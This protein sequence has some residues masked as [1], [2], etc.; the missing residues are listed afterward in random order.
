LPEDARGDVVTTVEVVLKK[1]AAGIPDVDL[2][3]EGI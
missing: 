1:D 2:S 3:T